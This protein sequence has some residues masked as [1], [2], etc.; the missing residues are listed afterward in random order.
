MN[1]NK[2]TRRL[3]SE[4]ALLTAITA[5]LPWTKTE[6]EPTNQSQPEHDNGWPKEPEKLVKPPDQKLVLHIVGHQ[7]GFMTDQEKRATRVLNNTPENMAAFIGDAWSYKPLHRLIT[8]LALGETADVTLHYTFLPDEND[9]YSRYLVRREFQITR[10]S[11][12]DP[13]PDLY[14]TDK[15]GK[16]WDDLA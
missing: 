1:E 16:G 3:F 14:L 4:A 8:G 12:D 6:A 2:P 7:I 13:C 10:H 5:W 11:Y 9:D 15:H